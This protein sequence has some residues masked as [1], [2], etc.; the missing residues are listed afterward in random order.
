MLPENPSSNPSPATGA[1]N[2]PVPGFIEYRMREAYAA[3]GIHRADRLLNGTQPG[4]GAVLM[5]SND[6][7]CLARHPRVIGAEVAALREEGHGDSLSRVFAHRREDR[8]RALERRI[9]RLV[10]TEDA[11]LCMSGYCANV[12]LVQ[13][14]A[15]P[16]TPVYVDMKAHASLWEGIRSAGAVARPFPHNDPGR[17]ERQVRQHGPGLV[18]V[19]ALY[20]TTGTI[21]PLHAFADVAEAH[22][23]ALVVDETHSFG[24]HGRDG[25][26]LVEALGLS[27][28]VHFRTFGLSKAVAARGGVIACPARAAD[29]FRYEALP[30]IFSTSVL[31]HEAAGFDAVLDIFAGEPWRREQLHANHRR[32]RDGLLVLGYPVDASDSQIIPLEAGPEEAVVTL[33]EALARHGVF[34]AVFCAPATPPSRA[35][36]RLTVN[37]GLGEE[38]IQRVLAA[39]KAIRDE[40]GLA[41]WPSR[42]R[43][44]P[45]H[46]PALM[47]AE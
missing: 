45:R 19:D 42:R 23:C 44:Q 4:P 15:A 20:S 6:Y 12:G 40:V 46:A 36:V 34:G 37:C 39:C 43:Q 8:H 41:R 3:F 7:L 30:M 10:G 35:M 22:G 16:G 32:L 25:A 13:A 18:L 5:R 14:F 17:L 26:G 24:A 27:G 28:R 31:G 33:R 9:A 1:T 11:V 2:P 38:E 47:A 21:A 29:F